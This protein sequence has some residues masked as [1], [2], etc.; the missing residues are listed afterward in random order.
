MHDLISSFLAH[1]AHAEYWLQLAR[2]H[3]R[4]RE[5][6]QAEDYHAEVQWH[7]AQMSA[8]KDRVALLPA[9]AA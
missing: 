2:W 6:A 9:T 1:K 5:F 4:R 7:L 3:E 8:I